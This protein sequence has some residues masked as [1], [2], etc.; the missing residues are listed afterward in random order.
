[1][2]ALDLICVNLESR[3]HVDA[4]IEYRIRIR[5]IPVRWR[6]RIAEWQPLVRF[7][8][9]QDVHGVGGHGRTGERPGGAG[10]DVYVVDTGADRVTEL[11]GE[12]TDLVQVAVNLSGGTWTL[13]DNL[14]NAEIVTTLAYNLTG[15][16]LNNRLTGNAAINRLLWSPEG[17]AMIGWSDTGHLEVTARDEGSA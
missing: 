3:L 12:G 9:E 16:A 5:G 15:N 7:V 6:T 8:D 10:D 4:R 13:G 2:R 1:V 14:E 11:A 17:L